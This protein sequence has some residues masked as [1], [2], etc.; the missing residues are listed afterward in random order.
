M[1]GD[2]AKQAGSDFVKLKSAPPVWAGT[3]KHLKRQPQRRNLN[4]PRPCGRGPTSAPIAPI[5]PKLKSAPPV[6]AGTEQG[7]TAVIKEL[8]KSAPPVWAG[9]QPLGPS[10]PGR[11]NLNPPRPCGRGRVSVLSCVLYRLLKS[12]PPVWAGTTDPFE[13]VDHPLLKSAPPVWAGTMLR[14]GI[15]YFKFT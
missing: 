5:M 10:A 7:G 11:C 4:P 1:G 3:W 14:I 9:T 8:L 12:A 15:T 6:W 2:K 13:D